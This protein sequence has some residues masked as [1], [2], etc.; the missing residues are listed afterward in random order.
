[1]PLFYYKGTIYVVN[2]A[3]IVQALAPPIEAEVSGKQA[4]PGKA[5]T[6]PSGPTWIG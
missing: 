1:M 6:S 4:N 3:G 2:F 5:E